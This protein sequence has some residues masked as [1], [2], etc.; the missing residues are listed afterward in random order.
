MVRALRPLLAAAA[1]CALTCPAA[2]WAQTGSP[3]SPPSTT[4]GPG[5]GPS[6]A[7]ASAD[8]NALSAI[9]TD[10]PTKSNATCTVDV[11]HFQYETDLFSGAFLRNGGV[12]TDVYLSP[13]PTLKYGVAKNVDIEVNIAPIEVVRT[14][15]KFGN[16]SALGGIGDLYLRLKW[17]FLNSSDGKLGVTALPYIKAPTAR[18]GIG[19]GE[20]EGGMILPISYKLTDK[21]TFVTVPEVDAYKDSTG[22]GRHVNTAQ[23]VN[24]GYSLP[25]NVTVYGELWGDWNFDPTGTVRQYSADVAAAWGLT[26]HLQVDAGLNFGL[27]RET[28]GV[29]AY[30]G[31]SQKF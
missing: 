20:V 14:H 16:E 15:D 17:N 7:S 28:P 2:A 18:S 4:E 29:Q 8:P 1:V 23:L 12:T 22:S 26:K 5:A 31:L 11:G 27:N 13:N 6:A 19:N 25:H 30:F 21:L 3:L 24:L 9:C 10:R